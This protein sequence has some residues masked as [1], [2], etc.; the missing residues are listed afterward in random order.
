MV[1][2]GIAMKKSTALCWVFS[3]LMLVPLTVRADS[4]PSESIKIVVPYAVGGIADVL[5]LIHI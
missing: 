5:S 3:L 1:G 2:K 4:F